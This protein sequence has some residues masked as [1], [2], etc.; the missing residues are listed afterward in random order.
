VYEDVIDQASLSR[1]GGDIRNLIREIRV[2][3]DTV[4]MESSLPDFSRKL[5]SKLV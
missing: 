1:I 5:L 2:I 3:P 4:F